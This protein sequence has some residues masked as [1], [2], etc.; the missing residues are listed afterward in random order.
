MNH[1][2][3]AKQRGAYY[4]YS[5]VAE[6]LVRWA[7]RTDEDLVMDPSF[8][9]GVFLDAVLQKL[10]SRASVGNR[11]FGVEIEKNTYEVVV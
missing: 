11:L 2:I 9:E 7:V 5:R 10:G 3:E 6:F 1:P 8:G 4:T